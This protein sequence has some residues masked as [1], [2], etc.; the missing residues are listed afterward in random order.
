MADAQNDTNADADANDGN[1][2]NVAEGGDGGASPT[3]AEASGW[4][5]DDVMNFFHA[6]HFWFGLVDRNWI[7]IGVACFFL[8]MKY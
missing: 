3:A 8:E 6:T 5:M 4:C 1:D 2:G 7:I